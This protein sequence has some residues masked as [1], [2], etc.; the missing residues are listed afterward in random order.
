MKD[1]VID[2]K[3]F[4]TLEEFAEHFS[5]R[6]L[7][8]S[9]QWHGNLNAFNDIL[10]GGFGTPEGGFRLVWN[11]SNLSRERLGYAETS[12]LLQSNLQTCHPSNRSSVAAKL[13]AATDGKG[14]T[15]FDWLVEII[16][17]HGPGGRESEDGVFLELR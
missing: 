5:S 10:R 11:N 14:P 4:S 3:Q 13:Q 12:R 2:G 1:Y 17:V 8:G 7:G 16:Q 6:V 15:I 9:Y